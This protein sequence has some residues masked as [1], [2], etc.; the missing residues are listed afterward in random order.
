MVDTLHGWERRHL[1]LMSTR[2]GVG[3]CLS[4]ETFRTNQIRMA[5][6]RFAERGEHVECLML[7]RIWRSKEK[8]DKKRTKHT[9]SNDE[10]HLDPCKPNVKGT[11]V[12][13]QIIP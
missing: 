6:K 11:G 3:R 1:D 9:E 5:R 12:V 2:K 4:L 13:F 10:K 7:Q 8:F